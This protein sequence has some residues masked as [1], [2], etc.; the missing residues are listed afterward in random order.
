MTTRDAE[1]EGIY[2][3]I[4]LGGTKI[5][6]VIADAAGRVLASERIPTLASQGPDGVINRICQ[7]VLAA[8]KDGKLDVTQLRAAGISAPGPIDTAAGVITDPP[9]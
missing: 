7:A 8:T 9:K 5:L 1:T 4:D 3:G 2:A 6:V